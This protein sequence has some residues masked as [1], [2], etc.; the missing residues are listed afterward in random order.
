MGPAGDTIDIDALVDTGGTHTLLPRSVIE[1]LGVEV[2]DRVPFRLADESTVTYDVGEARV[3]LDGR[4]LTTLVDFGPE[5][6]TPLL[7]TTT[8]E[9]FNL[10]VDPVG[11]RLLP[12]PGP[13][14]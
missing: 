5:G 1:A 6:K 9:L 8:L 4:Q 13:L 12:V 10:G 2:V 11:R 14:K 3:G 7:G